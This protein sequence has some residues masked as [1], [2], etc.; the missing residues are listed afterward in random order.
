MAYVRGLNGMV[1]NLGWTAATRSSLSNPSHQLDLA[2]DYT[3]TLGSAG[4]ASRW[5]AFSGLLLVK[6]R[7]Q[8]T[9]FSLGQGLS[10]RLKPDWVV[11]FAAFEH[12]LAEGPGTRSLS[13]SRR[14]D[15]Q[16]GQVFLILSILRDGERRR[17]R[18]RIA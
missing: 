18:E 11:D 2:F 14:A 13:D 5:S 4:A 3:G 16:S 9:S 17:S 12:G 15:R 7:G 8:P 6:P 1:A 10:Y